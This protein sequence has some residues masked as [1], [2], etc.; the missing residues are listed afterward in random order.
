M[1]APDLNGQD[2][3]M[4]KLVP[5]TERRV[6]KRAYEK[7]AASIQACGLLDPLIVYCDGSQYVILDGHLRYQILLELGVEIVPCIVW[8]EK[9]AFTPNRMVNHLSQAQEARMIRKSLDELDEKTIAKALGLTQI[10]HRLN[11]NLQ[12]KLHPKVAAAYESERLTTACAKELGFV[13]HKRQEEILKTMEGYNDYGVTMARAM[14][15]KTPASQ[16]AKIRTGTKTPW[17]RNGSNQNNLLKKLQDAEEQHDFYSTIYRQYSI[18]LLKLVVYVRRLLVN[19]RMREFLDKKYPD[20]VA[21][22]EAIIASAGGSS[23]E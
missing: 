19:P 1:T 22:F 14:V 4:V 9:E 5:L 6:A 2:I 10:K 12:N 23:D 16:R 8:K 7:I 11:G 15:L 13:T 17:S 21:E 3:P 18:N 20:T